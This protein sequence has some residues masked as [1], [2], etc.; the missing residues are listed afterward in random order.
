MANWESTK[1]SPQVP[2]M[3]AI[4]D[5]LGYNP[6]PPANGISEELVRQRTSPGLSQR[7]AAARMEV[8]PTTLARLEPGEKEPWGKF[9]DRVR[10]FLSPPSSPRS[11]RTSRETSAR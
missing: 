3:P 4:I 10:T 5:F 6:L 2:N 1:S 11:K 9:V 7:E 8:D